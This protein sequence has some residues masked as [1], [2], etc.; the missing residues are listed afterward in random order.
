MMLQRKTSVFTIL[1]LATLISPMFLASTQ[2]MDTQATVGHWTLDSIQSTDSGNVTADAT[3]INNGIVSGHPLPQII[4][5]KVGSAMQFDGDNLVYVPIKFV[6]GFPPMPEPMYIDISANLEIKKY[7]DIQ[8][9]IYVPGYKDATYNNIVVEC[10]HPD[11]ACAWQNTTRILGL[12]IRAGTPENGEQYVEGAL[13]GFV[14]TDVGGINEIVTNEPVP[15]N[16]WVNVEFARTATGMHLYVDGK[17]QAVQIL[18][19]TQNPEGN[20][21]S[22]TEYYFGH[23]ALAA[24]DD[25]KIVDLAQNLSEDAFDI[26]PNIMI[27]VIAVSLIFAVAWLL[28]RFIQ[29][30]I[31]RPK[32]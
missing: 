30:W 12:A 27:V 8:A 26:G 23:D 32:I 24:I 31:I 3:G 10:N 4:D 9:W 22:G 14:C 16:Q 5:G 7:F 21:M 29:L 19:G 13:S 17:E 25:V 15:L 18:S 28:R 6:V 1:L 20:V 11:Q 2:A